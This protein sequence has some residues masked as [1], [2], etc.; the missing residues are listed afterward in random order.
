MIIKATHKIIRNE[1]QSSYQTR[2]VTNLDRVQPPLRRSCCYCHLDGAQP[3]P[4][5]GEERGGCVCVSVWHL[6]SWLRGV[7]GD[8]CWNEWGESGAGEGWEWGVSGTGRVRDEWFWEEWGVRGVE[9]RV[10]LRIVKGWVVL[11]GVRSEGWVGLRVVNG[12]HPVP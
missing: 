1:A 11:R 3:F 6:R 5:A 4:T 10:V 2:L 12:E 8:R 7:R 9:R